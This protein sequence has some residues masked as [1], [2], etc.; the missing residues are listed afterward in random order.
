[1]IESSHLVVHFFSVTVLQRVLR[2]F[3]HLVSCTSSHTRFTLVSY[4]VSHFSSCTVLHFVM[5]SFRHTRSLYGVHSY[6]HKGKQINY[7]A[8]YKED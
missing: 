8:L 1:M 6:N 2:T 4:T 7:K 3:L 5:S